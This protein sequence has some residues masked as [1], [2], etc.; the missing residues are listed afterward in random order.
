MLCAP[1][2]DDNYEAY[3]SEEIK[4]WLKSFDHRKIEIIE[5]Y[6]NGDQEF[7]VYFYKV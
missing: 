6:M 3:K 1:Y 7:T 2:P 5:N 4:R